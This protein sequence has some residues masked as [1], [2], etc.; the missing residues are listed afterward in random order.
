MVMGSSFI[1]GISSLVI[2]PSI[3]KL[4][5]L[6]TFCATFDHPSHSFLKIIIYFVII[7]FITKEN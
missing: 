2:T 1:P 6:L 4:L 5:S 7:Y 3:F